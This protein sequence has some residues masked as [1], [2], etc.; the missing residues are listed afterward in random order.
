[1]QNVENPFAFK[2]GASIA[3]ARRGGTTASFDVLNKYFGIS[4]MPVAGS[5]YWNISHGLTAEDAAK[6]R[7]GMQTMRNLARNMV[8]M[9]RSFALA[10]EQG[11][12]YPETEG[13]AVTNFIQRED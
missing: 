10:K 8:W 5:T 6:D 13:E 7:E 1:M 3:V 4:Q 11:I 12:P 9:M 2:P